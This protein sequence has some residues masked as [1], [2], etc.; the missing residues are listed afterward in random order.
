MGAVPSAA[1]VTGGVRGIGR[2]IAERLAAR[3]DVVFVGD[4]EEPC[5]VGGADSG[6]RWVEMDVRDTGAMAAAVEEIDREVPL[7]TM[8]NN[9][10]VAWMR[11]LVDVTPEEFDDLMAVNLRG[12]FF[13]TQAAAKVMI[14]RRRGSIVN[15]AS[16]SSFSASTTP[17]TPYDT[18]KGGVRMLT[19]AAARELAP[20]GIRVNAVAP[21]TM[22]TDLTRRLLG[23]TGALEEQP[24]TLI[25]LGRLGRPEDVAGAV[26][27]LTSEDASYITGHVMAVDGGWLA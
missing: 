11:P 3:G 7:G 26:D 5:G 19:L 15:I 16:T 24:G 9:A 6:I 22:D 23:S 13:G 10:G 20:H 25:P 8:V 21:G 2:A 18:S 27:F 17:M 12:A 1:L 4:I 14:P